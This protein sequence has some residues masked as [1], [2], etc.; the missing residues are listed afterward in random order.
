MKWIKSFWG[1][2]NTWKQDLFGIPLAA[3]V[4]WASTYV[5]RMID[6]TAGSFDAGVVQTVFLAIFK[7]VVFGWVSWLILRHGFKELWDYF[8]KYF[9]D[10]WK[11]AGAEFRVKTAFIVFLTIILILAL[12]DSASARDTR[13]E[14]YCTECILTNAQSQIG[15]R[16]QTGNND[17]LDVEKYLYSVGLQRGN[18]W[19]A[20][21]CAWTYEQCG[22]KHPYSGYCP[23]WF[24]A[25]T[26]YLRNNTVTADLR[27]C[28]FGIWFREKKRIA[29]VGLIESVEGDYF[30]TIEGN[31]NDAGSREGDGVYR[32]KRLIKQVYAVRTWY[33]H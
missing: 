10:D 27:G 8:N 5:I 6:P 1:W 26:I 23:D 21:F 22:I 7:L 16:E 14:F 20:A 28:V 24:K 18:P 4:L 12:L 31:T 29:H 33:E 32:K 13:N 11:A 30:V 19:C 2:L 3:L 25:L 9:F 17:G 15:V